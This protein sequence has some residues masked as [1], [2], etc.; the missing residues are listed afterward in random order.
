[1]TPVYNERD[2][3]EAFIT[4]V[5]NVLHETGETFEIIIIDDNSPDGTGEL[6][7][8]L[9]QQYGN[10][11]VLHRPEKKGLG[12]AYKE[13][14]NL[15]QGSIIVTI[16]SDQSHDPQVLPTMLR[17][18]ENPDTDIVIGSR[19]TQGGSIEGRSFWRDLMS[20]TANRF[21]RTITAKNIKD[22]TSGLRVYKRD[23]W[24]NTMP[25]VECIKWDFQ[26]ESLY[27]SIK[28]GY[29]VTET[30]IHFHERAGG[31]SKFNLS[32]AIYFVFSIFKILI[33]T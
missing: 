8:E 32:E 23:V 31:S 29:Q 18:V 20:V 2:N 24:T 5:E 9:A 11:K 4:Q 19:F 1:M 33:T 10:I 28:D 27:K 22:W 26:F 16:D 17:E 6:A 13:G 21:I 12:T 25:H 3:L 7:E 15:T 30:P 14:F